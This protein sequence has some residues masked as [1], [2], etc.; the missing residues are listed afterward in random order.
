MIKQVCTFHKDTYNLK[1]YKE[2]LE[3]KLIVHTEYDVNDNKIYFESNYGDEPRY[4]YKRK[5]AD[6]VKNECGETIMYEDS[7]GKIRH[8]RHHGRITTKIENSFIS[9]LKYNESNVFYE[10]IQ[11]NVSEN[12]YGLF[13][14]R[15]TREV[16]TKNFYAESYI[17]N[18][19][20]FTLKY[21]RFKFDEIY[22]QDKHMRNNRI[23]HVEEAHRISEYAHLMYEFNIIMCSENYRPDSRE[24][25]KFIPIY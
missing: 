10:V 9:K 23:I 21:S 24:F 8:I 12:N 6:N 13:E 2:Y 15:A 16:G 7:T 14:L 18:S 1:S 19:R 3:G 25:R 22:Y 17:E 4:W 5:F 20:Y 11:I